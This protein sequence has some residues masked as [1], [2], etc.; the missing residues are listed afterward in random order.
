MKY[1][2]ERELICEIGQRMWQ[3]SYCAGNEGN[4]SVL[5]DDNVVLCTPS[6]VSK[7]FMKL[8]E[9]C[10]V[11][12]DGE[13]LSGVGGPSSELKMHIAIYGKRSDV[14][15]VVHAHPP[16]TTALAIGGRELPEGLYSEAEVFLGRI[17]LVGYETLSTQ[18]LADSLVDVVEN[19]TTAVMM[20]NHGAVTFASSL[21]QAYYNMEILDSYCRILSILKGTRNFNCIGADKMEELMKLKSKMG[22]A[23]SRAGKFGNHLLN[24]K[25]ASFFE[26]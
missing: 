6:G 11:S 8:G 2:K 7:G 12:L 24:E 9:L 22:I 23:D 14:K 10:L 20:A 13:I 15:A 16:Y 19:D 21:E 25:V 17:P 5:V 18:L 3:R 1:M 4:I 26:L